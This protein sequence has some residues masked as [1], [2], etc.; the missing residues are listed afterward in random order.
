MNYY[1]DCWR[2][3][4]LDDRDSYPDLRVYALT[5]SDAVTV[6]NALWAT[7]QFDQIGVYDIGG[8]RIHGRWKVLSSGAYA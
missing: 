2:D 3:R 4:K 7:D 1:V 8:R 5:E 6:S